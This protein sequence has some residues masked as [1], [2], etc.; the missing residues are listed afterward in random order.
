MPYLHFFERAVELAPEGDVVEFGVYTGNSLGWLRRLAPSRRLFGF[1]SF[2]GMPPTQVELRLDAAV[3]WAPGTFRGGLEAARA[4]V[5]GATLVK[6]LFA[7]LGPLEAY[8]VGAV[9]LAHLDCDIYEGYRDALRLLTPRLVPGAVMVFDEGAVPEDPA[10][11]S[12]ADHGVRAIREWQEESGWKR[13]A[14][15]ERA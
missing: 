2:E 14:V 4:A 15:A 12:V 1:D 7:D 6:G 5:P 8:G 9:A 13:L 11:A 3:M 10:W